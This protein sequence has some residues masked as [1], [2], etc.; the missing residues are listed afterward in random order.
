[1][2]LHKDTYIFFCFFLEI[3]VRKQTTYHLRH[4]IH[5]IVGAGFPSRRT[6]WTSTQY[7]KI[8]GFW[9]WKNITNKRKKNSGQ[10]SSRA[11]DRMQVFLQ[12][13]CHS[14]TGHTTWTWFIT[15]LTFIKIFQSMWDEGLNQQFQRNSLSGDNY[16]KKKRSRTMFLHAS[17]LLNPICSPNKY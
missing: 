15:L 7:L 13:C 8:H 1:M 12:S 17:P 3:F 16:Q 6:C 5:S 10:S 11:H 2:V 4:G 9:K 14:C